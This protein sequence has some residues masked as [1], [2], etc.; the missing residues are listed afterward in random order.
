MAGGAEGFGTMLGRAFKWHWNLLLLG[1]GIVFSVL[2]GVPGIVL[3][4]V[5][6]GELGYLGFLG[7]NRRF[8][9]VLKGQKLLEDKK[10]VAAGAASASEKKLHQLIAF[11]SDEDR[12]RFEQLRQ[13]SKTMTDLQKSMH[14]AESPKGDT[15]FKTQSLDKLLW[16]FLKLLHHKNALE[17]FLNQTSEPQLEA[18]LVD[19]SERLEEAKKKEAS[20]RLITSLSEKRMTIEER[21]EN[22]READEN[23]EILQIELDKTEQKINHLCEVGMTGRDGTNLSSQIDG[24]ADSVRLSEKTLSSLDLGDVFDDTDS[25]PPLVSEDYAVESA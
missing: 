8:Q 25:A 7:T 11:L 2:S 20:Q 6:A 5:I 21:L 18:E 15:G 4:I 12:E 19:T 1:S 14:S 23:L 17:R 9:N 16:L 3:P 22:Y 24:V 13:R 10:V